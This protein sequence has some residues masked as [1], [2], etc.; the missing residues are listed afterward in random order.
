MDQEI[1]EGIVLS[2]TKILKEIKEIKDRIEEMARCDRRAYP[3]PPRDVPCAPENVLGTEK[4]KTKAKPRSVKSKKDV[5][6]SMEAPAV[7]DSIIPTDFFRNLED[8][9]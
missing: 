1:M 6:K 9:I 4:P 7:P 2:Y 5:C 8:S 3:A